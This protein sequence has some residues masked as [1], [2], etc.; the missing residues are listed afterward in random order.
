MESSGT[1]QVDSEGIDLYLG[2]GLGPAHVVVL[3][4]LDFPTPFLTFY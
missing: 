3:Y 2:F 1:V 4:I